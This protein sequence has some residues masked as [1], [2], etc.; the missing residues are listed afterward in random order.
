MKQLKRFIWKVLSALIILFIWLAPLALVPAH[1]APAPRDALAPKDPIDPAAIEAFWDDFF[2]REMNALGVY[3]AVM[4]MVKNGEILFAKG[5]GYADAASG[6]PVDPSRTI[7]RA[8]SIVKTVTATAIMQLAEQGKLDLDADINDYLTAFKVPDTF[9]EPVT[10]R[11]LINMT[12]GFDT[13]SVGI[14]ASSAEE[15]KPLGAYLAEHMPPRVLLPGRYR[16]YNDHEVALAGY[17]VEVVSGMYCEQYVREHIFRPLEMSGSSIVLP[18]DQISRVARGYPVGGGP[19]SAYPLSYYH[20]NDAPGAGFNATAIDMGHYMIAHLQNGRYTRSDGTSVRILAEE[21]ARQMHRSAFAYHPLQPG[22]ANAFDEKFYK[23]QRYLRKQGGAPGMQN[24]MLLLLNQGVGFYLFSN[25]DGTALRND[26]QA[27]VLKLYLSAS[28][29]TPERLEPLSDAS[30]RASDYAGVYQQVSDNTSETT[31]VQVQA[32]V[33][34]DLWVAVGANPDGTLD[35]WGKRYVE[36]EPGVFQD[37][38]AGGLVSFETGDQGR[39]GFLFSE[40]TAYQRVAW[41]ETPSVQLGLLGFAILVFLSGLIALG[42]GFFRGNASARLL[43]GAVSAFNLI[44]LVGLAALLMPVAT[45]GDIWQFSFEPSLQ[46]RLVLAIPLVTTLLAAGLLVET[47]VA[48]WKD[49]ASL[50]T[51]LHN[52]FVLIAGAAFLYFLNTWNLLGWRF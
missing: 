36:V 21:T 33:D 24:N 49:R 14:R 4:V 27:E 17:L 22:Q 13:R 11:H 15:V 38:A 41:M 37:P 8:G 7:L 3:G 51:R 10:A 5:Y 28:D 2:S 47:V 18:D 43:S 6:T 32:L 9:P 16:R 52:S 40:R 31:L 23:G 12:G 19:E 20:L 46:L 50:G 25:S 48:W 1:A 34:P 26:W 29:S 39:A 35:I 30:E 42:F 45:G 44:F